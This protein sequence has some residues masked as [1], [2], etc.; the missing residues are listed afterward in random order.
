MVRIKICGI[1]N[2]EDY[3]LSA[4]LGADYVGFVF[5]SGSPRGVDPGRAAAILRGGRRD[6]KHV[7][8]FVNESAAA[9]REVAT[10]VGLDIL[11]FHGEESPEYCAGLDIPY[12][13]AIRIRN[14]LSLTEIGRYPPG[15]FLLDSFTEGLYGGTGKSLGEGILKQAIA[16]PNPVVVAGGISAANVARVIRLRPFAVDVSSSLEE[17]PG[18]KNPREMGRFFAEVNL[19]RTTHG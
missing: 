17:S 13:K 3:C 5:F 7:G 12:W 1:T 18:K 4:D 9:V 19:G 11:Q 10:E 14:R 8:V 16:G 6:V 15:I 2:R